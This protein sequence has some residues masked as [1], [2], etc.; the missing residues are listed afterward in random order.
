MARAGGEPT[1]QPTARRLLQARQRGQVAHSRELSAAIGLLAVIA[2]VSWGAPAA[3]ARLLSLFRATF[4]ASLKAPPASAILTRALDL[5]ST[6]AL[7]PLGLALV[8]TVLLGA[9]QTRGLWAWQ[10]VAPDAARLSPVAGLARVFSPR[11]LGEVGKGLL[12][13]VVVAALAFA[14]LAAPLRQLPALVGASPARVLAALGVWARALG[15][16]VAF[17]L[18][19][20]ALLDA[21]L[22]MRRHRRLLMM[23]RD[24]VKREFKETEGD[25]QHKA[26]R[27]R[28]HRQL[29]EQRMVDDVRKA[30]FVVVNPEHIAVAVRYDRDADEAPVVVAKGERLLAEQIKQAARDAGVP[31]YRDVGLARALNGV[32]QGG[33]SPEALYQAVAEILRALQEAEQRPPSPPSPSSADPAGIP[34]RVPSAAWRRV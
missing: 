21:L 28:L 15:L 26:E 32:A 24:E 34:A 22:V 23:T 30:A 27:Q 29:A 6:L 31:I 11:T 33:E 10:A 13:L 9:L 20:L 3:L 1:E 25:P 2:L 19:A 17:A 14:G 8:S 5:A 16:R 7:L 12:K 4:S 18:L